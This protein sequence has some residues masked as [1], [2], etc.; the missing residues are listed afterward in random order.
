M[1]IVEKHPLWLRFS[2][3]LNFPLLTLMVWS[4]LWIYWANDVYPG[5][6]PQGFYRAFGIDHRLADGMAVHFTIAWLLLLNGVF[7]VAMLFVSRHFRELFPDRRSMRD[8]PDTVLHDLGLIPQAP[9]QGKFNAA[10][11]VAYTG[12][13]IIAI[14]EVLTGFAIYKPTQLGWLAAAF[15][16]YEFARFIHFAAML[17][18]VLFFLTHVAQVVRAGW[19]GFRAMIA[20]FEV[21]ER[22]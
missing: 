20:G 10:Q 5:F 11:R 14:A 17:L 13:L 3:W 22:R 7:Y 6:F 2:H 18:L 4:G 1:K 16:G 9:P 19:N 12:V 21:E 15:G 8:L